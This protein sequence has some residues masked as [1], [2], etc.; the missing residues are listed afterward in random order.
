MSVQDGAIVG[1][2]A[3]T[4]YRKKNGLDPL[5]M[6]NSSVNLYQTFLPGVSNV[7]LRMRY[8][9]LYA[10]LCRTYAQRNGDT[11]PASWRR[12]VRRAEAIYALTAQQHGGEGG[13]AGIEWAQ[14]ILAT[15]SDPIEFAP[16]TDP[17]RKDGTDNYLAQ[18]WGA[19]GAAYRS[20]LAEIGILGEVPGH[21]LPAPTPEMG[22]RLAD[23]FAEAVGSAAELYYDVVLSGRVTRAQLDQFGVMAPSKIGIE[24]AERSVYEDLLLNPSKPEDVRPFARR[25]TFLLILKIAALLGCDPT[26][27]EVRWILY[28]GQDSKGQVLALNSAELEA[29]RQRWWVYHANDLCHVAFETLL[30]FMLDILGETPTG[31]T[32]ERLIPSCAD[33]LL[34][35]ADATPKDWTSF[36]DLMRPADNAYSAQ[37][38]D[39]EWALSVH[40]MR[41]AGRLEGLCDERTAWN[42][43]KLLAI[44]NR[45]LRDDD[46]GMPAVLGAG[47]NTALRSL[48]TERRFLDHHSDSPFPEFLRRLFEER[49]VQ[50]HLWVALMKLRAGDYT[51]LI[52]RDEGRFRLREKDGPVFTNPRL[53]PAIAFLRDIH[54]IG[55]E[56]L[57]A[58]GVAAM[59]DA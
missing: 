49:I 37:D 48:L 9:G 26:P 41:H 36:V 24:G 4:E 11:D 1:D 22:N 21:D 18:E 44:L 13:V 12:V 59:G 56:G 31:I 19:Y 3:W 57:T 40:I 50:R 30:K 35:G 15:E 55:A 43:V 54:L 8:Y 20:Q 23:A 46:R 25:R 42:A 47:P 34:A 6:Q 14:R 16:S 17:A 38:T 39:S 5:G 53:G 2:P 29:H 32:L 28:A 33:R 51:Y 58:L 45:R 52:E 27:D 10:W 7:T